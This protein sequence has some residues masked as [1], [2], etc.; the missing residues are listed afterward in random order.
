METDLIDPFKSLT[1]EVALPDN[2]PILNQVVVTYPIP[3]SHKGRTRLFYR[4]PMLVQS[5]ILQP[6][7][8]AAKVIHESGEIILGAPWVV[9]NP[10]A[11]PQKTN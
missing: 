2:P 3:D 9:L 1:V 5:P 10:A 7:R 4:H 8:I 11:I 6:G